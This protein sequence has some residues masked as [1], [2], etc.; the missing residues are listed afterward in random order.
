MDE[1]FGVSNLVE[2]EFAQEKRV[3]ELIDAFLLFPSQTFIQLFS[4]F[5]QL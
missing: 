5:S 2:Q 4:T 3:C 1:E